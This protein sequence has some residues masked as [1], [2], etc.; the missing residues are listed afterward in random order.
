MNM[1]SFPI[2]LNLIHSFYF[3]LCRSFLHQSSDG[4]DRHHSNPTFTEQRIHIIRLLILGKHYIV[5]IKIE[6]NSNNFVWEKY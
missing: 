4:V 1:N 5:N 6:L 2:K 3:L